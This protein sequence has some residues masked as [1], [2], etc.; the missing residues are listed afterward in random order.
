MR[1]VNYHENRLEE[2]A[3][4]W[5][6]IYEKKPYILRQDGIT[7]IN[8]PSYNPEYF[9]QH[10][11]AA[12]DGAWWWTSDWGPE[13]RR[14]CVRETTD[15][16]IILVEDEGGIAGVLVSSIVE[17]T[18]T[19]DIM[20]CY[21]ANDLRGREIADLL[22]NEALDRFQR[23]GL[24]RAVAA[25]GAD[26][27]ME[28]ESPIHLAILDAGF[29]WSTW[30]NNWQPVCVSEEQYGVF[31][32][33]SLEGFH[34]QPEILEK[35]ER[36]CRE[37]IEIKWITHEEFRP[38]CRY[39]TGNADRK[40][41]LDG[42]LDG[43]FVALVDGLGVGWLSEIAVGDSEPPGIITGGCVPEVIPLYQRKGIGTVLYHLGMDK[44][45]QQGAVCGWTGTG[46]YSP[47]RLIYRSIGYR[48]WCTVFGGMARLL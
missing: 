15:D 5:W 41:N 31:L 48:Y 13:Q 7:M 24:R 9:V 36:L 2:C 37:G 4:F 35:R 45:V 14:A 30:E 20:S 43:T 47:A 21:V 34:L 6:R 46:I 19:G 22:V 17:E 33:G 26:R 23:R 38:L 28:V 40:P 29:G 10:L 12:F 8:A 25:P 27:S 3:E 16:S 39:D 32:G 44:V 18:R 1:I 42:N 11:K